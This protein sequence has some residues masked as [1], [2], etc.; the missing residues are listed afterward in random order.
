MVSKASG[1]ARQQYNAKESSQKYLLSRL[2]SLSW[3]VMM[4]QVLYV[5]GS[6]IDLVYIAKLGPAP[7]AGAGIGGVV[8][9]IVAGGVTG[10]GVGVRAIIA[11]SIGASDVE[12][13]AHAA[14]QA[15]L[16]GAMYGVVIGALLFLLAVPVMGLFGVE[17]DVL[18]EGAAYM[19]IWAIA[20]I[21]LSL[22]TI[23]FSIMQASGDTASPMKILILTRVLHLVIDPF[24]IFGLWVIPP[25][26]VR[27]AAL[28]SIITVSLSFLL[29]SIIVARKQYVRLALRHFLPNLSMVWR[30]IKVGAPAS[31][32]AIQR[33]FSNLVL[34]SFMV[35]F[36]TIAVA[37][38]VLIQRVDMV[39]IALTMGVGI[40]SGVL[41]GHYIGARQ[42]DKTGK[43]GWLAVG[44]G[45]VIMLV[46]SLPMVLWP[47]TVVR[48]FTSEPSQVAMASVF[49]RIAAIGFLFQAF[50]T[51]LQY[52]LSG[53][54][55]TMAAMVLTIVITWVIQMPAAYVVTRIGNLAVYGVRWAMVGSVVFGAVIFIVYFASGRW[56]TKRV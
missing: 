20:I 17:T 8:V 9:T 15:I 6:V 2:W 7:T 1:D 24:L 34:T 50:F 44:M 40:A 53:S 37:S 12:G 30:I 43:I 26:G 41:V 14:E 22:Y 19:Q 35:P 46:C 32:M 56:K 18:R 25:L 4:T 33:S 48:I 23:N 47:E 51:V 31:M 10:L 21:P 45:A 28:T 36:G 42:I 3:Q 29:T 38:H 39:I 11:R 55:D 5:L 54:G 52:T 13:A 16:V 27:G 49:L